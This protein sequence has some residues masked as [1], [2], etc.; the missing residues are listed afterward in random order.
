MASGFRY[1]FSKTIVSKTFSIFVTT[2]SLINNKLAQTSPATCFSKTS[3]LTR[4]QGDGLRQEFAAVHI[5]FTS[6]GAHGRKLS[7]LPRTGIAFRHCNRRLQRG[8]GWSD[9]APLLNILTIC[10]KVPGAIRSSG[11][12][13]ARVSTLSAEPGSTQFTAKRG[14]W[15][16]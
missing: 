9:L 13:G 10:K 8:A 2:S 3:T 4:W 12:V 7:C 6:F 14:P 15:V 1:C 16:S 11:V 5:L